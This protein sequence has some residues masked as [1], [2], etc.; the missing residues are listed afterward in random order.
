[1]AVTTS[2]AYL[3]DQNLKGYLASH[4]TW[5]NFRDGSGSNHSGYFVLT[6]Q[7]PNL[8]S[9]FVT[10]A[11]Q[12]TAGSGDERVFQSFRTALNDP[13][14]NG[15]LRPDSFFAIII[16]SDEDDFSSDSRVENS[17]GLQKTDPNYWP[18]HDYKYAGLDTVQ[19]YEDYLDGLTGTTGSH[20]RYNVNSI[21]VDSAACQKSYGS[22]VG[23]RY[24]QI[25]QDTNG[26]LGSVCN[27]SYAND[28]KNM[29]AQIAVLSTQFFLNTLPDPTSIQVY[30]SDA[31]VPQDGTD[32]WT[33]NNAGNSIQFHGKAVPPQG[34]KIAVDFVP[35]TAKH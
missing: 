14:N 26:V 25:T 29:A 28:L 16:L 9:V 6:P 31:L 18:D 4:S 33:Y 12:G 3:A 30:V 22:I 1:M 17:F 8:S 23:Q 20:R 7:V 21:T 32:G 15:F 34:A 2:D 27:A 10:N 11:T 5:G 19:S 35:A 13:V 24:V